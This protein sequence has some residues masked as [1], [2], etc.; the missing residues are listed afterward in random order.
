[1]ADTAGANLTGWP[2]QWALF[3]QSLFRQ[4]QPSQTVRDLPC[5]ER[6]FGTTGMSGSS[7]MGTPASTAVSRTRVCCIPT[8][9]GGS[10][11]RIRKLALR[12]PAVP[13]ST[14]VWGLRA[15][16]GSGRVRF[17]HSFGAPV[18]W[19]MYKNRTIGHRRSAAGEPTPTAGQARSPRTRSP[20]S[21]C[22]ECLGLIDLTTTATRSHVTGCRGLRQLPGFRHDRCPV[23][24]PAVDL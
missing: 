19:S 21:P 3:R 13:D 4:S 15:E 12:A 8:K 17:V 6:M 11:L 7:R 24:G 10:A 14:T 23:S 20:G 5:R 9:Q 1:M 22:L 18:S 2:G 16:T